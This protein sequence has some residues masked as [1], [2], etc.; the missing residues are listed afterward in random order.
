MNRKKT[1]FLLGG[2]DLEMQTIRDILDSQ[3]YKYIDNNLSWNDAKLSKYENQLKDFIIKEPC[4][5]VFGIELENDIAIKSHHYQAIDH[6]N[7]FENQPCALEQI[8]SLLQ[9]STNRKYQLIAANDKYYIPGML[10]LGATMEEINAIRLADRQAQGITE[11]D[12]Q[13][14]E[15]AISKQLIQIGN[16]TIIHA[17]NS[18]FSP[19]CDRLFPYDSLLIYT[20]TEWIYY[21]KYTEQIKKKFFNEYQKGNLFFGGGK[22]GFIGSKQNIYTEKEIS[23]FIKYIKY[24]FT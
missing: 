10:N 14:A 21:G 7:E 11:Q 23:Q 19:I 4:G 16:L 5:I 9:L 24:E 8:L 20:N 13:M 22:N 12:E 2:H 15:E 18:H 3:N 17:Y 6:H 1:L